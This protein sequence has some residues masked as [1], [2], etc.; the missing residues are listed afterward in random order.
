LKILET[1]LCESGEDGANELQVSARFGAPTAVKDGI[2]SSL[3]L[4][5]LSERAIDTELKVEIL[6]TLKLV[7]LSIEPIM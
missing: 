6:K 7:T 2:K 3:G 1:N 5:I 4:S